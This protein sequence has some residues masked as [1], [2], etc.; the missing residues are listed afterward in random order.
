[1]STARPTDQESA[2]ELLKSQHDFP[3]PFI[4]RIVV[5]PEHSAS[6]VSAVACIVQQSGS[7]EKVDERESRTGRFMSIHFH[8]QMDSAESVLEVYAVITGLEGVVMSL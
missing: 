2:L 7:I 4:F 3:G 5:L 6:I 8:C 1:M